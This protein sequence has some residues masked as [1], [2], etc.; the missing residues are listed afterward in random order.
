[1]RRA[2]H[3]ILVLVALLMTLTGSL[4]LARNAVQGSTMLRPRHVN[5][6]RGQALRA[7]GLEQWSQRRGAKVTQLGITDKG[8][9]IMMVKSPH[10]KIPAIVAGS[11]KANGWERNV[12]KMTDGQVKRLGLVTPANA[13]NLAQTH[14]KGSIFRSVDG[15][16]TFAGA[17]N[18]GQSYKFVVTPKKP[19]KVRGPYGVHTIKELTRY[20][21]VNGTGES[22]QPSGG[23][24]WKY[25]PRDQR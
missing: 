24:T 18:K 1:M 8:M 23:S 5:A 7:A 19:V 25:L 2:K 20:I 22:A 17:S 14:G 13:L 4:A 12:F 9:T 15:K 21:N 11:S 6:Y 16:I 3:Y 10:L